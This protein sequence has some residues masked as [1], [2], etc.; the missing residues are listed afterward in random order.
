MVDGEVFYASAHDEH[1]NSRDSSPHAPMTINRSGSRDNQS[2]IL[3]ELD[4]H[5]DGEFA[6]ALAEWTRLVPYH[7]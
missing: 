7:P 5:D 2:E 3:G 4:R 6:R 1:C